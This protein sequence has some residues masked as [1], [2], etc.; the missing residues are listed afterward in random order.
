MT[1]LQSPAGPQTASAAQHNC[2]AAK[3]TVTEVVLVCCHIK[4]QLA[5]CTHN[6][7]CNI[8]AS[9]PTCAS[10]LHHTTRVQDCAYNTGRH[11]MPPFQ[12]LACRTPQPSA[13]MRTHCV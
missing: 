3:F 9:C 2:E 11:R 13:R 12:N 5:S 8:Q 1:A 10:G 7:Q 4:G 6:M